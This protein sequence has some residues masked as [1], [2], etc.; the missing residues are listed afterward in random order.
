MS[1]TDLRLYTGVKISRDNRH[2]YTKFN[3]EATKLIWF[4]Q[5]LDYH[6]SAVKKIRRDSQMILVGEP[7]EVVANVNYLSFKNANDVRY[8]CFVTKVE[9]ESESATRLFIEIDKVT[10][11]IE[12]LT[13]K[14][15]YIERQHVLDDTIGLHQIDENLNV[16]EYIVNDYETLTEINTLSIIVS[17]T[18]VPDGSGGYDDVF[19][20]IYSGVYSGSRL[21]AFDNDSVGVSALNAFLTALTEAG[22]ADSINSIFLIPSNLIPS[23]S[24]G[25]EITS[26][27]AVKID[28]SVSKNIA[29]IDG[30]TPKNNKMFVYPYNFLYVNNNNGAVGILRYEFSS[31]TD[32]KFFVSCDIGASPTVA[33]VPKYYKGEVFNYDELIKLG[34]YP[35]CSWTTD[36]FNNWKAQ[37]AVSGP[38]SLA[39]GT[40]ALTAGIATANPIAIA[41]GVISVAG[42]IGSY[43]EKSIQPNQSKGAIGGSLN[44][45]LENQTFGLYNKTI[46]AEQ[47]KVIDDFFSM[48]GYKVNSLEIPNLTTRP[49]WNYIKTIDINVFGDVPAG[50]LEDIKTVFNNGVTFWHDADVGNYNRTNK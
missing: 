27:D 24:D 5:F 36:L 14:S 43:Y 17:T 45:A 35:L 12:K 2:K 39:S 44:V 3:S 37:N 20:S 34:D 6:D 46:R 32:M 49:K 13:F 22:K 15:C 1:N 31:E 25:D 23:Y 10:T 29:T 7:I 38:L 33:L 30:Y 28:V 42:T 18:A 16:G 47:A 50:D 48:Y 4:D 41:G 21:I 40:L 8:Y 9:Y 11:W 26:T 19:G